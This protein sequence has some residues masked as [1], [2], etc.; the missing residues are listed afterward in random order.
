MNPSRHPSAA[1]SD[2]TTGNRRSRP[3]AEVV[4]GYCRGTGKDPFGVMSPLSTCQVCGGKEHGTL[5]APV[6]RCKFCGGSGVHPGSR[7]TCLACKGWGVVEAHEE[8]DVCPDC[9]GDGK[10][11]VFYCLTCRGQG[12][13]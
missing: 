13:R 3:V 9:G 5:H 2:R 6:D 8:R 4:C 7:Q 11:G 1:V 12:R 10:G